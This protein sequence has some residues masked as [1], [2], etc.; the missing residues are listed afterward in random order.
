[1]DH[2]ATSAA[3]VCRHLDVLVEDM[4]QR[5]TALNQSLAL[6]EEGLPS[7]AR[8]AG[9]L[10]RCNCVA[11]A[12]VAHVRHASRAADR[13]RCVASMLALLAGAMISDRVLE[14]IIARDR[15]SDPC[16]QG[17]PHLDAPSQG[18]GAAYA[19]RLHG[20]PQPCAHSGQASLPSAS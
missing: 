16:Q 14:T 15:A 1:M 2:D 6:G 18:V 13:D 12:L 17:T 5:A 10:L 9:E 3:T 11:R 8:I 19:S 4:L 7:S 20:T